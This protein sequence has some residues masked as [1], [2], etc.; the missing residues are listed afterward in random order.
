MS[1]TLK[2]LSTKLDVAI[3]I[4]SF[5]SED[6]KIESFCANDLIKKIDTYDNNKIKRLILIDLND[7]IFMTLMETSLK[8]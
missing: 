4:E 5:L 7:L 6:I 2:I 3:A 1:F 8:M